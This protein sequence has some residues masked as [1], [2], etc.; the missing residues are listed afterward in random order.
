MKTLSV[1]LLISLLTGCTI[2]KHGEQTKYTLPVS[3]EE[4]T[5]RN[6]QHINH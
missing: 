6:M 1:I 4:I 5:L 3:E 2:Q